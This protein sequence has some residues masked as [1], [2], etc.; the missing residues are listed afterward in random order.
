MTVFLTYPNVDR[1]I[2]FFLRVPLVVLEAMAKAALLSLFV[3]TDVLFLE[4]QWE[5]PNWEI[6]PKDPKSRIDHLQ[7]PAKHWPLK[8]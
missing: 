8:L 5:A 6:L 3:L 7:A 2:A 1:M 4:N